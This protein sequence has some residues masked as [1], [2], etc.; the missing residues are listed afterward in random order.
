MANFSQMVN[1]IAPI[2]TSPQGLFLQTIYW[3]LL[4]QAE[5]SGP[6]ALDVW[7]ESDE[8]EVPGWLPQRL[9]LLDVSATLDEERRVLYVSAVNLSRDD[10]MTVDLRLVDVTV[11]PEGVHY[12]CTGREPSVTNSFAE[13]D[14][15]GVRR[16]ELKGLSERCRVTLPRHSASVLELSLG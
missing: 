13:P 5:H 2:F 4:L 11:A 9:P 3:P 1:V 16:E 15:V 10:E 6:I 8:V 12:L 7:A 14:N